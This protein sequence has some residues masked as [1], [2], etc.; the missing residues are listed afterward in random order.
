M[1]RRRGRDTRARGRDPESYYEISESDRDYQR[2]VRRR[3]RR[4][5]IR[6]WVIRIAVLAVLSFAVW[7]WGAEVWRVVRLEARETGQEFKGVGEHIRDGAA[8]RSGAEL[9]EEGQ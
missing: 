9:L 6:S 8:R 1:A 4:K 5:V 7:M 3:V 2:E